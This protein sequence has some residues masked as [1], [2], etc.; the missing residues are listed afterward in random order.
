MPI[1]CDSV[2]YSVIR[3]E[4]MIHND[5]FLRYLEFDGEAPPSALTFTCLSQGIACLRLHYGL[6]AG[7][8]DGSRLL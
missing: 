8:W 1:H 4:H 5:F 3:E 6:S 2:L 7:A